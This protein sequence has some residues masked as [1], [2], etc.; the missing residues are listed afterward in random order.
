MSSKIERKSAESMAKAFIQSANPNGWDGNGNAPSDVDFRI[1]TFHLPFNKDVRLDISIDQDEGEWYHYCELVDEHDNCM[2]QCEHG[3]GIDS[4]LNL[5]DTIMD[6][7][8]CS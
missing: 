2:V 5:A 3:Y 7:V 6:I 8:N 1:V 4:Y